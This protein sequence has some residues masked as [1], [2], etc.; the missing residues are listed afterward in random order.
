MILNS[1]CIWWLSSPI[2]TSD[3]KSQLSVPLSTSLS[4][5]AVLRTNFWLWLWTLRRTSCKSKSKNL[6]KSKTNSKSFWTNYNP[7]YWNN[8]QKQILP[9]SLTIRSSLTTWRKLK[10][11]LFLFRNSL[12]SQ[13]QLKLISTLRE[14]S[15]DLWL[16]KVPCCISCAFLCALST[17]CIS[18]L[19]KALSNSSSK[20][21]RKQQK[22]MK[23]ES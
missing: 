1:N 20:L 16:L 22:E 18:T 6:W 14:K 21:Y 9:L 8:S 17:I 7:V 2:L 10:L 11:L 19:W 12:R 13:R 5:R 23:Q 4:H 3:L 15:I